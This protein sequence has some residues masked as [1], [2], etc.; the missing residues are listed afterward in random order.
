VTRL[1]IVL[2]WTGL[3]VGTFVTGNVLGNWV[4][5]LVALFLFVRSRTKHASLARTEASRAPTT[6]GAP[7]NPDRGAV[8]LG[9]RKYCERSPI[10]SLALNWRAPL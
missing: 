2:F 4:V 6:S 8:R 10:A 3:I 5:C 1:L 9:N 7:T